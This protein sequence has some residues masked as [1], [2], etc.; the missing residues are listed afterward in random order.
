[1]TPPFRCL[2]QGREDLIARTFESLRG[3]KKAIVHLYNA[4]CPAFRRIVFNQD[5]DGIKEIA[6]SAAKLFVKYAPN[7]RKPSG[8]SSTRPRP[9]APLSWNSPKKCV[10][11]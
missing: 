1:M 7:S 5:K 3:A 6:V 4:T 9:S 8:H 11:R 10:T 2:T